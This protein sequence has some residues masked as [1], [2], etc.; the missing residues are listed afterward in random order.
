M[1]N[2]FIS[3]GAR[4]STAEA[5]EHLFGAPEPEASKMQKTLSSAQQP[6]WTK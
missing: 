6:N 4:Q 5:S 3:P 2:I 1:K